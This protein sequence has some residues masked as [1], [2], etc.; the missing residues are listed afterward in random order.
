[1]TRDA[2]L[3]GRDISEQSFEVSDSNGEPVFTLPFALAAEDEDGRRS[4]H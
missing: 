2:A 4:L 1:M 3:S